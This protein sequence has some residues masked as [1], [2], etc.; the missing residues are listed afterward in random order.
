MYIYRNA[1]ALALSNACGRKTANDV[2]MVNEA[3]HPVRLNAAKEKENVW[4]AV[5]EH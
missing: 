4:T 1:H 2:A 3:H 5:A